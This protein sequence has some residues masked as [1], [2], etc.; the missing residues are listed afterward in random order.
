[1][2]KGRIKELHA[3]LDAMG[4]TPMIPHPFYGTTLTL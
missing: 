1:M 4:T 2:V 3:R